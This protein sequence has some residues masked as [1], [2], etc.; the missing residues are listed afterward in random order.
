MKNYILLILL[1]ACL[2]CKKNTGV[3]PNPEISFS[4]DGVSYS[5]KGDWDS[6]TMKGCRYDASLFSTLGYTTFSGRTSS[7]LTFEAA[8]YDAKVE[9]KAYNTVKFDC[10]LNAVEYPF[11]K[12]GSLVI[13]KIENDRASGTF[14]GKL[15]ISSTST[16]PINI[17]NG[18]F[19]DVLLR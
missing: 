17:T 6:V 4:A 2:G 14:T 10:T 15:Y 16:V 5:I 9:I 3:K 8:L 13:T 7:D 11:S 19:K 1:I 12:S 18:V